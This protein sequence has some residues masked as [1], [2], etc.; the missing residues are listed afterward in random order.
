[1]YQSP[2]ETVSHVRIDQLG[3]SVWEQSSG[4]GFIVSSERCEVWTNHHVVADAALVS[5]IPTGWTATEGID[6]TV[7][8]STPRGDMAVL[9]SSTI[10]TVCRRR[11]S[12]T[13][14]P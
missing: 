4:S 5:V 11:V 9:A 8:H 1:M 10:A 14:Q 13:I 6:A 12:V 7:V 2:S 3:D